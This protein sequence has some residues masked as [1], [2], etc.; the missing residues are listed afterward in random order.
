[1]PPLVAP[2]GTADELPPQAVSSK[3]ESSM[4]AAGMVNRFAMFICIQSAPQN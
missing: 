4:V 3:V 1:V 2:S